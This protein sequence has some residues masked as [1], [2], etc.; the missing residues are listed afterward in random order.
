MAV[1]DQLKI[2]FLGIVQQCT[3]VAGRRR[4]VARGVVTLVQKKKCGTP[5]TRL[6]QKLSYTAFQYVTSCNSGLTFARISVQKKWGEW[7]ASRLSKKVGERRLPASP[8]H[9]TPARG[10]VGRANVG[11][12]RRNA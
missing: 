1:D 6:R 8:P 7:V 9:Y 10:A 4:L 12:C 5:E 2:S 3:G 11:F